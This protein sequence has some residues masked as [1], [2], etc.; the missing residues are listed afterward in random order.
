MLF[1]SLPVVNMQLRDKEPSLSMLCGKAQVSEEEIKE[2][3]SGIGFFYDEEAN[4]F[5]EG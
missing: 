2:R 5:V 4:Q 3:L 1:R